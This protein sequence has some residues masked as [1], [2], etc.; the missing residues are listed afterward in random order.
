[1]E[2]NIVVGIGKP[3]V[4]KLVMFFKKLLLLLIWMLGF[5]MDENKNV[6]MHEAQ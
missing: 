5:P 1:L 3:L 2:P 4:A 6:G